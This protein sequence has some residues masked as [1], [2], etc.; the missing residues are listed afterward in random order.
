MTLRPDHAQQF[1]ALFAADQQFA[2]SFRFMIIAGSWVTEI[3]AL[4][5]TS[6]PPPLRHSFLRCLPSITQGFNLTAA[7]NQ[8]S[9]QRIFYQI[10]MTRLAI[11]GYTSVL[12]AIRCPYAL[13]L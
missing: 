2:H 7:Q 3:L 10:I 9:F 11:F 6:L 13:Q 5:N 1:I 12:M 4:N 8:A